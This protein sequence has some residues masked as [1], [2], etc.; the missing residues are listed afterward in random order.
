MEV[1]NEGLLA[2]QVW[3]LLK[4]EN[5]LVARLLRL[6]ITLTET[7]WLHHSVATQVSLGGA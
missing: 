6:N 1:F 4:D 5:S 7:F 2:K 3:C